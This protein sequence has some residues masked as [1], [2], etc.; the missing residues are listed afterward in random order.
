MRRP[1]RKH[2]RP[3]TARFRHRAAALALLLTAVPAVA[4]PRGREAFLDAYECPVAKRLAAIHERGDRHK[5]PGRFLI[6]S[7]DRPGPDYVQ[8][9]FYDEDRQMMCEAA[10]GFYTDPPNTKRQTYLPPATVAKLGK[11]GFS[12]DDSRGNFQ[13]VMDTRDSG[14]LG[15][16]A[17]LLLRALYEAYGARTDDRIA[18]TAPLLPEFGATLDPADCDIR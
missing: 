6:L 18:V 1:P 9:A 5:E 13:R 17:R 3:C 7:I 10:S 14:G 8:C 15:S 2:Y 12:T 4:E 16:V 11:L